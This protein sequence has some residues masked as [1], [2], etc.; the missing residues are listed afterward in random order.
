MWGNLLALNLLLREDD[1]KKVGVHCGD[2]VS[3]FMLALICSRVDI[4]RML[5]NTFNVPLA[6]RTKR[7]RSILDLAPQALKGE[8]LK[9]LDMELEG[10]LARKPEPTA[11]AAEKSSLTRYASSRAIGHKTSPPLPLSRI[12]TEPDL[13]QYTDKINRR[14][15]IE[16]LSAD[17]SHMVQATR[18]A[19]VDAFHE[20]SQRVTGA[21]RATV[22][23]YNEVFFSSV[24]MTRAQ[25]DALSSSSSLELLQAGLRDLE[26]YYQTERAR[27]AKEQKIK[28]TDLIAGT[29]KDTEA[30]Q[31]AEYAAAEAR[32]LAVPPRY[33][34]MD[35]GKR[36]SL[37]LRPLN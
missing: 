5:L 31:E 11:S 16:A 13:N 29:L 18:K 36:R 8:L 19:S 32:G 25:I 1:E 3:I 12:S 9:L 6:V 15:S 30:G 20:F 22:D 34:T 2:E 4:V 14:G 27:L 35:R 21:R 28:S 24:P 10:A 7:G 17:F 26:T 33:R 23:N 37:H